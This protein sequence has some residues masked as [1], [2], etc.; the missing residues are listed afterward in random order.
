[1]SPG[2]ARDLRNELREFRGAR[3]NRETQRNA[4]APERV[5][6]NQRFRPGSTAIFASAARQ[7]AT[8]MRKAKAA[9]EKAK[10][11]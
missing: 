9:Q 2:L 11:N 5:C 6:L 8:A 1:V 3:P 10:P 7:T 4:E